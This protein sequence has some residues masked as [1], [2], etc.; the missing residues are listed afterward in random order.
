MVWL[1]Q[2]HLLEGDGARAQSLLEEVLARDGSHLLAHLLRAEILT[3]Q[4]RYDEATQRFQRLRE[5]DPRP[6]F[7]E[8]AAGLGIGAVLLEQDR[9]E[10][11]IAELE[12]VRAAEGDPR[13]RGLMLTTLAEAYYREGDVSHAESVCREVLESLPEF[14][15]AHDRI[16]ICLLH[17]H[18][19]AGNRTH[20][21]EALQHA[22]QACRRHNPDDVKNLLVA[23]HT[24]RGMVYFRM[25]KTDEA[26]NDLSHARTLHD[27][28]PALLQ[29]SVADPLVINWLVSAMAHAGSG[30]QAA[31]SQWHRLALDW[32]E[33]NKPNAEQQLYFDE[34]ESFLTERHG[35]A[36]GIQKYTPNVQKP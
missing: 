2:Q 5:A 28:L 13:L 21:A 7:T 36:D 6:P 25:G 22:N 16:A 3:L 9:V 19:E 12:Q 23:F 27:E 29:Q 24:T 17:R 15:P 4:K 34:A 30:N 26:L 33:E 20:L 35:E 31:A 11:A 10:E 1:A 18:D 8:L 14:G 32:A